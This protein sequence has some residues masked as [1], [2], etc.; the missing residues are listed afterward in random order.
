M[1]RDIEGN[2]RTND[3]ATDIYKQHEAAFSN[4]SAYVITKNG[5]R[6]ATIAFKFPKDGASK[7]WAYVHWH[8]VPMVRG[9]AGG[10]GY[11]KRSAACA[12]AA[13]QIPQLDSEHGDHVAH[14]EFITALK[15]DNGHDWQ[16]MLREAGFTVM[17]AV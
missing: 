16:H 13:S 2:E 12:T 10:Y 6:V 4:V 14:H 7:L 1:D 11:D 3:M 15:A 8:G 5:E 17:Q 9:S